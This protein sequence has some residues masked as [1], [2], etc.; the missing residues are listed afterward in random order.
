MKMRDE[1]LMPASSGAQ[2]WPP[3]NKEPAPSIYRLLVFGKTSGA[4]PTVMHAM[5]E[6]SF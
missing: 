1:R 2:Q 6:E 5:R 3:R 4:V